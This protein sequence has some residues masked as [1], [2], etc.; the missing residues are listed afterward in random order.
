MDLTKY[1]IETSFQAFGV[2]T[3]PA[4]I[5]IHGLGLC[6]DLW[7]DIVPELAK[8]YHVIV[9]DLYGHGF[10]KPL[11]SEASLEIFSTQIIDLM[12]YLNIKKAHFIGFSIGGM[13]NRKL[14][15]NHPEKVLS[16]II[17]NSPHQ[18][19][20]K[21]QRIVEERADQVREEGVSATLDDA[22]IR[23]FTEK[24]RLK[25]GNKIALV[26]KWRKLVDSKSY[27][28]TAK[29]LALG[30]NELTNQKKNYKIR[31]LVMTCEKDSGSTPRMA[32]EIA[33]DYNCSEL[34]L[35]PYL[36]HLG[37]MEDPRAFLIPILNFLRGSN[38]WH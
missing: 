21:L 36:R 11:D 38:K 3:E 19:E 35:V 12:A 24:F 25:Y 30:V 7:V 33:R 26:I 4:I 16:L 1:N 34:V 6:K 13:I 22:L 14:A 32:R 18:R 29:V 31:T 37:L 27:A 15:I 23:W 20:P 8:V 28:S 5:L 10:S 17:L 9:Y 2:K